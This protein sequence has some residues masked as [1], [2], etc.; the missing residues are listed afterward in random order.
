MYKVPNE[1]PYYYDCAYC[2]KLA[3]IKVYEE[4]C[5]GPNIEC[6]CNGYAMPIDLCYQ[7]EGLYQLEKKDRHTP[8]KAIQ[9][10]LDISL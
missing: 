3:Q 2:G 6:A 1:A 5:T 10:Y 7:C 4:F 9:P 8:Y